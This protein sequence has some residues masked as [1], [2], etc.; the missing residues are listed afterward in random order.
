[1]SGSQC[2]LCGLEWGLTCGSHLRECTC[3]PRKEIA[4]HQ[5]S[6]SCGVNGGMG[7]GAWAWVRVGM[8]VCVCGHGCVGVWACAR[9]GVCVCGRVGVACGY[10]HGHIYMCKMFFKSGR[11]GSRASGTLGIIAVTGKTYP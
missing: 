1:M 7:V 9:V 8:G 5:A 6:C 11:Y 3:V 10:G 2:G 4:G